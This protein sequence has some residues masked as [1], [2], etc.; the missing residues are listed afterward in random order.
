VDFIRDET[1]EAA[2][3]VAV[4]EFWEKYILTD[5]PPPDTKKQYSAVEDTTWN[6]L[7][8]EYINVKTQIKDLE[9]KLAD[10]ESYLKE[11][12]K[13][14][15]DKNIKGGGL[16]ASEISRVGAVNYGAIPQ[17]I[18]VDLDKFRK[19]SSSYIKFEIKE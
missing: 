3:E 9:F 15:G 13:R 7:A 4:T 12:M 11:I 19:P 18:G 17:L 6:T 1:R 5:T 16:Q 2:L 10:I 14:T 8:K